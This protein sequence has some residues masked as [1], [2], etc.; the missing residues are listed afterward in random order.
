[1][2]V[3][4]LLMIIDSLTQMINKKLNLYLTFIIIVINYIHK[5]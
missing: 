1:M 2:K 4:C 3:K 5:L